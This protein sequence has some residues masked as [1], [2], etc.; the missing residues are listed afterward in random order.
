MNKHMELMQ[1]FQAIDSDHSGFIEK[2]ELEQI[3]RDSKIEATDEEIHS[4]I[5]E[6][7]IRNW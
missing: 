1:Q 4:I 6:L 5:D 3:L 7:A 2:T